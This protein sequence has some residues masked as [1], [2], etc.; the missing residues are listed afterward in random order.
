MNRPLMILMGT[1]I[2]IYLGVFSSLTTALFFFKSVLKLDE[3]VFFM[4]FAA[5]MATTIAFMPVCNW[6]SRR[7]GKKPAYVISLTG[8]CVVVSTWPQHCIGLS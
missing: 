8:F 7:I 4:V 2:A 3:G 5:Q 6:V 1:K